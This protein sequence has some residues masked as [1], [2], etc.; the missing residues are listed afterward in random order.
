M[1][2]LA[3]HLVAIIDLLGQSN[4]LLKIRQLPRTDEERQAMIAAIRSSA[5]RV[6]AVRESF[7]NFLA[8]LTTPTPAI[9]DQIPENQRADFLRL[10]RTEIR[11]RWFSDT[12]VMSVCLLEQPGAAPVNAANGVFATLFGLAGISLIAMTGGIALRGGGCW[13]RIGYLC[14]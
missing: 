7:V 2:T 9:L 8:A 14:G 13:A 11:Q 4:E 6:K 10:R 1:V 12:L 5:G 3:Y